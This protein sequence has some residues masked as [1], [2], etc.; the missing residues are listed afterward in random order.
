[1]CL[2]DE[3]TD[4]SYCSSIIAIE[5]APS[6]SHFKDNG[7][8]LAVNNLKVNTGNIS[9]SEAEISFKS[10]YEILPSSTVTTIINI[11]GGD[12][13]VS[14]EKSEDISDEK[15]GYET[16]VEENSLSEDIINIS[17]QNFDLVKNQK[18]KKLQETEQD[19]PK[20]DADLTPTNFRLNLV[21]IPEVINIKR[22]ISSENSF[23]QIKNIEK[24]DFD[25]NI[26]NDLN[27]RS[28]IV[29][30]TEFLGEIAGARRVS[31]ED[32]TPVEELGDELET[33]VK[34]IGI[35]TT[36]IESSPNDANSF[37]DALPTTHICLDTKRPDGRSGSFSARVVMRCGVCESNTT[38]K[39]G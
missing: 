14:V 37:I 11:N 21:N 5:G 7:E 27:N 22:E 13:K 24:S 25:L 3:D 31:D 34:E 12:E 38:S 29:P 8:F 15:N 6:P 1:M 20:K 18:S 33:L 30:P 32:R 35:A 2:K 9:E 10:T 28:E 26:L 19:V 16:C 23:E 17:L 39:A 4:R 36:K